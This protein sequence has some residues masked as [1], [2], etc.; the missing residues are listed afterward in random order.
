[1]AAQFALNLAIALVL[2]DL[3]S[4]FVLPVATPRQSMA[5]TPRHGLSHTSLQSLRVPETAEDVR[6]DSQTLSEVR[7]NSYAME[8]KQQSSSRRGV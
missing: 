1:M 3:S 8:M 7:P 5:K 4:A 2:V 6:P